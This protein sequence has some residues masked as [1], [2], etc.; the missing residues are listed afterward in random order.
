MLETPY[1]GSL[2]KSIGCDL[3]RKL[4]DI[5]A[6][7]LGKPLIIHLQLHGNVIKWHQ[8]DCMQLLQGFWSGRQSGGKVFVG[9]PRI[10][11]GPVEHYKQHITPKIR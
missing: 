9:M 10:L 8:V 3:G 6:M 1:Y 2:T 5:A 11:Y 7:L 4:G